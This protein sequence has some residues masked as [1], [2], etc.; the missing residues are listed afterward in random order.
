MLE[1]IDAPLGARRGRLLGGLPADLGLPADQGQGGSGG[2]GGGSGR[3][4]EEKE[5]GEGGGGEALRARLLRFYALYDPT[6]V[7]ARQWGGRRL[8]LY[9]LCRPGASL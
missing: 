6:K 1:L 7:G 9:P 3:G 4:G 8:S 5:T 2:G